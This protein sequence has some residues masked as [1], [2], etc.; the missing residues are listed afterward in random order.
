MK[1][2]AIIVAVSEYANQTNLPA[3]LNDGNAINSIISATNRF[4]EVLHISGA[5]DT[6]GARAQDVFA[7]FIDKYKGEDV[8]EILFYFTGHG[9]FDGENLDLL[10]S[11]FSESKRKQTSFQN[12]EIDATIRGLSPDIYVKIIDACQSGVSYIKSYDNFGEYIKGSSSGLS[13][14]YFMFSSNSDQSSY[15]NREMSY[16]TK[17]IV[18]SVAEHK[19]E[20]LRYKD[21]VNAIS[22]E[23]ESNKKQTPFFVTQAAMTE[24]FADLNPEIR[25][26]AKTFLGQETK[27]SSRRPGKALHA[28]TLSEKIKAAESEIA[29]EEAANAGLKKISDALS[30]D[31]LQ[32]ELSDLYEWS[33]TELDSLPD[34]TFH[35]G[36]WLEGNDGE[37]QFFC[38]KTYKRESYT[39]RVPKKSGIFST[40]NWSRLLLTSVDDIDD[41]RMYKTVNKTRMIV[42]GFDHT[43]NLPYKAVR[44]WLDPKAKALTP[45]RC[46]V[47]PLV[48]RTRFQLFWR[49]SHFRYVDWDNT[50]ATLQ[51]D[52][53]MASVPIL[54]ENLT[55]SACKKIRD[56]FVN[57][58]FNALSAKWG[59]A[60]D[61]ISNPRENPAGSDSPEEGITVTGA[62][63][64][65]FKPPS[66]RVRP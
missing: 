57:Y 50:A 11:D 4:D 58:V 32:G 7:S 16:F 52:W 31:A 22:D 43:V 23:Y 40:S 41:D 13:N 8:S 1:R 20:K 29:S 61:G 59:A 19:T 37:S 3:C 9:A 30:S 56:D 14:V 44:I 2:L 35:I 47:I 33:A 60:N 6:E 26:I 21:I 55:M 46:I 63:I 45:E 62:I 27:E 15:A 28:P 54:D 5:R 25:K 64:P 42:D 34:G 12:A 24:T 53:S 49:F 10:L 18:K 48:S 66:P 17:S 39:E 36:K 51:S 65:K 38:K